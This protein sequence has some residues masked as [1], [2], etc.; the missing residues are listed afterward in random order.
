MNAKGVHGVGAQE[1]ARNK[2]SVWQSDTLPC[3]RLK[4]EADVI[5][6]ACWQLETSTRT[7][8]PGVSEES[9]QSVVC[10]GGSGRCSG[11]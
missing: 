1:C 7:I 4:I 2:T 6:A 8:S 3:Y 5:P 9:V 10:H 11:T